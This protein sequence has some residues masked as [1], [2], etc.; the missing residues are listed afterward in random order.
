MRAEEQGRARAVRANGDDGERK[1]HKE[2]M[3]GEG[4]ALGAVNDRRLHEGVRA[5][6]ECSAGTDTERVQRRPR[7]AMREQT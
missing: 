3:A 7:A 6:E 5:V 2:H 4:D 1:D